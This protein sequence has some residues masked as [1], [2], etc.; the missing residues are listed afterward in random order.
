MKL[1][2]VLFIYFVTLVSAQNCRISGECVDS[3]VVTEFYTDS[4]KE[5][6][7]A[8]KNTTNCTW[9]TFVNSVDFC[10]LFTECNEIRYDTCF[11]CISGEVTCPD[12]DCDLTGI[13]E[14]IKTGPDTIDILKL[15]F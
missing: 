8:C 4:A 6:L 7:R 2:G 5:C 14:V 15:I 1:L 13:C 11:D 9:Y 3:D 10:F 12:T